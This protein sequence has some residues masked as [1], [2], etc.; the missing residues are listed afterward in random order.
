MAF[1]KDYETKSG[2]TGNYWSVGKITYEKGKPS[3]INMNLHIS[4]EAKD[5]GK[6]IIYNEIIN[7]GDFTCSNPED[8]T[9]VQDTVLKCVYT[10]V[11]DLAALEAAKS[12]DERNE[13]LAYFSDALDV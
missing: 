4:K 7:D 10:H 12:E 11:K 5:S 8:T 9:I 6:A 2:I 13:A 1:Q 3:S